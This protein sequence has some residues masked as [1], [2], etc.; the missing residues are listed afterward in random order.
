MLLNPCIFC[1]APA[2]E[3]F[4]GEYHKYDRADRPENH[5]RGVPLVEMD[6]STQEDFRIACSRYKEHDYRRPLNVPLCGNALGWGMPTLKEAEKMRKL[7]NG[8]NPSAEESY[9]AA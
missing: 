9:G 5:A 8:L 1:G 6:E 4:R 7:W 2:V 3:Q